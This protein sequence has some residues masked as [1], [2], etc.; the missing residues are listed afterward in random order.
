MNKMLRITKLLVCLS[1]ITAFLGCNATQKKESTGE[2]IDD[3][4][5]TTKIKTGIF[6]DLRLK[7][8]QIEVQTFKGVVQ[9][10]GFVD[11]PQNA[12]IAGEIAGLVAGVKEVKNDLVAK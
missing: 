7:S 9:L 4:A 11:S 5:I 8:L 12:K 6:D 10:S 2:Y 3:S 1:L